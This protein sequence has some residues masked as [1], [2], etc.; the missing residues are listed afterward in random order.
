MLFRSHL[1]PTNTNCALKNT[2]KKVKGAALELPLGLARP[3]PCEPMF[4]FYELPT[5]LFLKE[6]CQK[7][8]MHLHWLFYLCPENTL[9]DTFFLKIIPQTVVYL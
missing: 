3:G 6:L 5:Q 4:E 8:V 1:A 7:T 2:P 9:C